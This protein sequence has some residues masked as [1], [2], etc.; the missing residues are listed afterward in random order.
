MGG[1]DLDFGI[2]KD[3][4]GWFA[5]HGVIVEVGCCVVKAVLDIMV[6]YAWCVSFTS[7]FCEVF[8]SMMNVTDVWRSKGEGEQIR[9]RAWLCVRVPGM[10]PP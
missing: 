5:T 8:I 3:S 9:T 4:S 1:A 2:K 10:Y 7:R 6:R